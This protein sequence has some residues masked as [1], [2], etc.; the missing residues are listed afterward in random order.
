MKY[1]GSKKK[2]SKYLLP[3]V[4]KDRYENQ[5]YIEPFVG[6][7]NMIDKVSGN[8]IGADVNE[9]VI[10]LFNDIQKGWVPPDH[11]T[12]KEYLDIKSKPDENKTLTAWAGTCCS[13]GS[14]WFGGWI[15]KYGENKKRKDGTIPD[16][17]LESKRSL[18]KQKALLL[19][20]DFQHTCYSKLNIPPKSKIYCDPPYNGTTGYKD[21]FNHDDFWQWCREQAQDGHD[22]Y[23]SEYN[24]PD[25]FQCIW[26][27][28]V[29]T[30]L[31]KNS[32]IDHRVEKLFQYI[33]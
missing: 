14:K 23:I 22:V 8:R 31:N 21:N 25:D 29:K 27:M 33:Q 11:I 16:R 20:I 30:V 1:M 7:A 12:K 6:G 5:F 2:I 19:G 32:Q 4:L 9:Y 28:N 3:I 24:A 18:I 13:F 17:Q 26:S 10:S 15:D